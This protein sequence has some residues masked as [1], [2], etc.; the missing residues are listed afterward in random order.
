MEHDGQSI[1]T[2]SVSADSHRIRTWALR[3]CRRTGI[4]V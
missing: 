3:W 2:I 4:L 1:E